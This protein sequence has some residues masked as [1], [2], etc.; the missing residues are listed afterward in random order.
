MRDRRRAWIRGVAVQSLWLRGATLTRDYDA[1]RLVGADGS[2]LVYGNRQL[3]GGAADGPVRAWVLPDPVA[4]DLAFRFGRYEE[5]A[6]PTWSD[7][8]D[9]I[10]GLRDLRLPR[11]VIGSLVGLQTSVVSR[12]L[13]MPADLR[14]LLP[15]VDRRKLSLSHVLVLAEPGRSGDLLDWGQRAGA[16]G[17][18]VRELRRRLSGGSSPTADLAR[19][20]QVL[21]ESLQT[22]VTVT[23]AND[24]AVR[25]RLAWFTAGDLLG[26]LARLSAPG[27][28][29][30]G[31][32]GEATRRDLVLDLSTPEFEALFGR[33]TREL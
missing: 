1:R 32:P 33:W 3:L 19:L 23:S 29:D 15:L 4:D 9:V 26:M 14:A 7:R 2:V 30:D 20:G 25:V 6:S 28:T 27:A 16:S 22:E 10:Q 18:S 13:G 12:L 21:S 11:D 5:S 17:W 31:S 24:G 8:L